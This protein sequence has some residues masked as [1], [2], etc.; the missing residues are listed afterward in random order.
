VTTSAPVLDTTKH[1]LKRIAVP[2][3]NALKGVQK[4]VEVMAC[5]SLSL[6]SAPSFRY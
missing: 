1:V 2:D 5:A 3:A 4:E 6:L